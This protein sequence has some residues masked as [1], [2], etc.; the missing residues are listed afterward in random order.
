M[1]YLYKRLFEG[2]TRF[3]KIFR[4]SGSKITLIQYILF[5]LKENNIHRHSKLMDPSM[6]FN[7]HWFGP[8]TVIPHRHCREEEEYP[9]LDTGNNKSKA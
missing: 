9:H 3:K 7:P 4:V 8:P 5:F 6:V 1:Y 2:K